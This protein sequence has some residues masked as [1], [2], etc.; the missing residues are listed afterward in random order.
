MKAH[1]IWALGLRHLLVL[2]RSFPRWLEIFYWPLM[3]LLV[4]GFVTVYLT[5][6]GG[7]LPG[8]VGFLLGALILWDLLFR[9]QQ[10]ITVGFLEDVWSRNLTNVFVSPVTP[11]E[12][13]V[14]SILFGLFKV[15]VAMALM[16]GLALALYGFNL[17]VLGWSLI[18]LALCLLVFG[19]A[20]GIVTT[21]VILRYG[22]SAEVL[23]WGLPFLAMPFSA[24]FYPLSVLPPAVQQVAWLLPSAHVFEG[25]RM[26][27]WK[28]V[29][30]VQ[31]LVWAAGLGLLYLLVAIVF[32]RVVFR[33]V[34]VR[35]LLV[36]FE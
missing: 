21:A 6:L 30:P 8:A 17:L 20:L 11:G 13:L 27:L 36:R 12:F 23:A 10:T 9:A 5:R 22:P 2:R 15:L 31:H 7:R 29:V 24:V 1:R 28:G 16:S 19:W 3:D 26:V 4:W 32:F 25:M 18:P 35:G 14:S 33:V 34:K